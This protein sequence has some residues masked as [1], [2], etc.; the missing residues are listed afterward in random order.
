MRVYA[1]ASRAILILGFLALL[2]APAFASPIMVGGI[3]VD[4]LS[5]Q[6]REGSPGILIGASSDDIARYIP[7]GSY[8]MAANV[9]LVRTPD[10]TVLIDTGY[11]RN[12]EANL[13]SLGLKPEDIDAVLITH[14][15]GDH[16]GGLLKDGAPA[17]PNATAYIAA[18]EYEWSS[19]A[20]EK[21]TPYARTELFTPGSLSE[22]AQLLTGVRPVA[23]YGHTPGHT[24][25]MIESGGE[26]LLIW[27]DLTH[28]MAIQIPLPRVSVTYDYDPVVAAMARELV[29]KHVSANKIPVA[30]MH[31]PNPASGK[32]T[33]NPDVPG[34][35]MFEPTGE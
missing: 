3:R 28:A 7:T 6:Q 16:I 31:I 13:A 18:P 15:H 4:A 29:L 30:G 1:F 12:V 5:E 23:A 8:P 35:Y 21:L 25:F 11:G 20:R 2:A 27:A 10:R 17:F 22:G 34:G 24:L 26:K 32:I 33:P 9:F 14:S 19:A